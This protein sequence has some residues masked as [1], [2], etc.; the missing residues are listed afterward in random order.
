MIYVLDASAIIAYLRGEPGGNRVL[1]GPV[2][3]TD[4]HEL[5]ALAPSGEY[6]ITFIR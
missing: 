2:L 4:H 6:E 3:S 1:A 5:D